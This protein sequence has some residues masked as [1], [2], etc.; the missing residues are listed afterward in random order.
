MQV[1]RPDAGGEPATGRPVVHATSADAE[2]APTRVRQRLTAPPSVGAW[3]GMLVLWWASL[4]PSMLPRTA[5]IQAVISAICVAV[6]YGLGGFVGRVVAHWARRRDRL[7]SRASRRRI[8]VALAVVTVVVVGLGSSRW[9]GWQRDQRSLVQLGGLSWTS[10]PVMLAL[11]ALVSVVI[12]E[13]A[14]LVRHLVARIDRAVAKRMQQRAARW[15]VAT[16]V[17]AGLLIG[18]T[19]V[20]RSFANWADTNFGTFDGTTADGVEPPTSPTSSGSP[21]SLVDWDTLGFEG[22]NFVAGAPTTADIESFDRDVTALE[23]I[24][25]YVGLDSADSV[26]E[27]V[28][29]AMAEL[30]R[31]GAFERAVLVAVTPTGTGW[32][33]PDAARTIEYMYGGDTAI[34]SVQYSFLPS[35]IAFLLD[36]TSPKELG[37]ALFDG[38][39]EAWAA[40]PEDDRPLLLAFGQSLGS[41]GG[42]SAFAT[43]S[44]SDSIDEITSRYDGALFT[45]PTRDNAIYGT[46]VDERDPGSPSWKP[47]VA[48]EPNVRVANRIADI[49]A[50]DASWES[51]RV[52]WVHHP[53]DA[54][55]T[56]RITN[57]WSP[58]GWADDPAAYDLPP[59]ATWVPFV[60]FVQESF[61][62]MAG[63]SATPG[64]G[65][66]YRTDFVHSWAA[67]APPEGWTAADS[68]RLRTHLGLD[69]GP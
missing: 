10:V 5:L 9:I 58:P 11:T 36:T 31:T 16:I 24:R 26:E 14:R 43:P 3:I 40:L 52:L 29:L 67:I 32:V 22:R 39:H 17:T 34:V 33:D 2:V 41:M 48:A 42:E 4:R 63:F 69:G 6:G 53:S 56:W 19:F 28:D 18:S 49:D 61:D 65:H 1:I 30:E 54:I 60:T 55:G 64:F 35:W 66:D 45:G 38:I 25:V 21:A 23:P 47:T 51:P 62:L 7:P 20:A 44:L 50:A 15:T 12:I 46:I 13:I 57:L 8:V 59:A 68:D 37:T 27:R